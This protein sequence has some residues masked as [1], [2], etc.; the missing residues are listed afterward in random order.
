MTRLG[1]VFTAAVILAVLNMFY[2]N[3]N[4]IF[5]VKKIL[6]GE[7]EKV[8][9]LRMRILGRLIPIIIMGIMLFAGACAAIP[10][11]SRTA[12]EL[13]TVIRTQD[14]ENSE[15]KVRL[16][17]N[18]LGLGAS[19]VMLA[20]GICMT[21]YNILLLAVGRYVYLTRKGLYY[22]VGFLKSE[23]LAY[24]LYEQDGRQLLELSGGKPPAAD[25]FIVT[26]DTELL[27]NILKENYKKYKE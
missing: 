4:A 6:A 15:I 13:S 25:L 1:W 14:G 18:R 24:R 27:E 2:R 11:F 16:D 26:G 9:L 3:F 7:T 21:T 17:K 5:T 8:R 10:K 12:D 23:G 20:L 19:C 22:P